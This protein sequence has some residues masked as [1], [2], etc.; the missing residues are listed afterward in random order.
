MERQNLKKTWQIIIDNYRDYI[1]NDVYLLLLLLL[2]SLLFIYIYICIYSMHLY[3]IRYLSLYFGGLSC[4][5]VQFN[6]GPGRCS[7]PFVASRVNAPT[8]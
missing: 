7:R 4:K 2:S 6:V 8:I 5:T 1:Y 3:S